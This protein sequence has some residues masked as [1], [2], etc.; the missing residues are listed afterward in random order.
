MEKL[1]CDIY[2]IIYKYLDLKQ[3][4]KMQVNK[5][6][7]LIIN[8]F[9]NKLKLFVKNQQKKY[10]IVNKINSYYNL[11]I[12]YI[13]DIINCNFYKNLDSQIINN[14]IE[15]IIQNYNIYENFEYILKH[16]I[17]ILNVE[18]SNKYNSDCCLSLYEY[19]VLHCM[20]PS[21]DLYIKQIRLK[22][23]MVFSC[24]TFKDNYQNFKLEKLIW[25]SEPFFQTHDDTKKS[26]FINN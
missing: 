24:I 22:N 1:N 14:F 8:D 20:R 9:F 15:N 4:Y 5:Y 12:N 21:I 7:K 26:F 11:K 13:F 3:I 18:K 25:C 19:H 23:N 17:S 10:Y 2:L 16:N 6:L